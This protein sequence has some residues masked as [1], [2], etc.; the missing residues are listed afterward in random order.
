V[1]IPFKW[2]RKIFGTGCKIILIQIDAKINYL[3]KNKGIPGAI[4]STKPMNKKTP[5]NGG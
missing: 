2:I 5:E 3:P 1:I 4:F